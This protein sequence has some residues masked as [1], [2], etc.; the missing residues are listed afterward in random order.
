VDYSVFHPYLLRFHPAY[1]TI[2][3]I[4]RPQLLLSSRRLCTS[5]RHSTHTNSTSPPTHFP[6]T[7]NTTQTRITSLSGLSAILVGWIVTA[8]QLHLRLYVSCT[9]LHCIISRICFFLSTN[10]F[11]PLVF[12]S[13]FDSR[14]H[15]LTLSCVLS[16]PLSSTSLTSRS[17]L[18]TLYQPLSNIAS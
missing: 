9:F 7:P 13:R 17:P 10:H 18:C 6:H 15:L 11:S 16:L 2:R 14:F 1:V 8:L 5:T 4:D 3:S 12:S